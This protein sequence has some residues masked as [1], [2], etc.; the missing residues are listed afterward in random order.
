MGYPFR[1]PFYDTQ[2]DDGA[3]AAAAWEHLRAGRAVE[4]DQ[5]D[6]ALSYMQGPRGKSEDTVTMKALVAAGR[7]RPPEATKPWHEALVGL[8]DDDRDYFRAARR[9]GEALNKPPRIRLSTIHGAKGGECQNVVLF[10]DMSQ[11]TYNGFREFPDDENRVFYVGITRAKSRLY[12]VQPKALY[13][14]QV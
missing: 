7:V 14:F 5:A 10:Q 13:Y 3:R 12:I 8:E 9:R 6:L 1:T 11:R 2:T 4:S